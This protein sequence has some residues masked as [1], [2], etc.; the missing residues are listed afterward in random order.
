MDKV[1]MVIGPTGVGKSDVG[2]RLAKKLGTEIISADSIQVYR[3][4]NIGS[5]K[6]TEDEA[7]G[8]VQ[9][10]IDILDPDEN[11]SV[12]D[13]QRMSRKI[14]A[15][16]HAEKKVPVVVGGTGLYTKAMVYDYAFENE[17]EPD[18]FISSKK[19]VSSEDLYRELL[20]ADPKA[21][22]SIHPNNRKRV[23][24]ALWMANA[25]TRK[26]DVI[27]AQKHELVYDTFFIELTMPKDALTDRINRRV[28]KMAEAGLKEEIE[29]LIR[30]YPD[31]WNFQSMAGIGYK[32]WKG[33]FEG[34]LILDETLELI[35]KNTRRFVKRQYTWFRHQMPQNWYDV[36]NPDDLAR[37]EDDLERWM[38]DH[39]K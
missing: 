20:S 5:A 25:G 22:E 37:M 8:V 1:I 11:Y 17:V 26:S 36:T 2:I 30:E 7:D 10:L 32:E 21:A 18:M 28:D 14:A 4:L 13:F 3:K 35:K 16:L 27:E 15:E 9:H 39:E 24:R 6:V 29:G 34:T 12:C 19:E 33:Y 23:L 31:L 38:N